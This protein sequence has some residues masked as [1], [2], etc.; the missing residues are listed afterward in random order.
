MII[1]AIQLSEFINR[2]IRLQFELYKN[3]HASE[4]IVDF[5]KDYRSTNDYKA[6]MESILDIVKNDIL[7]TFKPIDDYFSSMKPD[8]FLLYGFSYDFNDALLVEIANK[9]IVSS[10][11]SSRNQN[12]RSDW[13]L[14]LYPFYSQ[15]L[16]RARKEYYGEE[17]TEEKEKC[18]TIWKLPGAGFGLCGC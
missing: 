9:Y 18:L 6:S 4:N 1:P 15:A 10:S 11:G 14:F 5:K 2:C 7:K 16:Y 8:S 3:E 13:L 12:I 17:K